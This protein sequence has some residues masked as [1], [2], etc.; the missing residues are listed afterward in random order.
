MTHAEKARDI[1]KTSGPPRATVGEHLRA[2]E[3]ALRQVEID[4]TLRL[5]KYR[6]ALEQSEDMR[7]RYRKTLERLET[8]SREN[9]A[10]AQAEQDDR[11][12]EGMEW[13]LRICR[14]ALEGKA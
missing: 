13:L 8:F 1:W 5:E 9:L 14:N 2:I 7:L 12:A 6:I 10:A 3:Q 4:W 11:V